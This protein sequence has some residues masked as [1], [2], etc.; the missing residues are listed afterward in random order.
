MP[1]W[2]DE[3]LDEFS[4]EVTEDVE[5]KAVQTAAERKAHLEKVKAKGGTLGQIASELLVAAA[6]RE[7]NAEKQ[8]LADAADE[9]LADGEEDWSSPDFLAGLREQVIADRA[10]AS[11]S[12]LQVRQ[13]EYVKAYGAESAVA[14]MADERKDIAVLADF[15]GASDPVLDHPAYRQHARA[16]SENARALAVARDRSMTPWNVLQAEA[17]ADLAATYQALVEASE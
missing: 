17:E 10:V 5:E 6:E 2:L 11:E 12:Y 9:S 4:N 3:D 8:R 14:R 15:E 1:G 16:A 13:K 7:A